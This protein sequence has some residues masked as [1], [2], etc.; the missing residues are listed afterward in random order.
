MLGKWSVCLTA[1][2]LC[3]GILL[4]ASPPLSLA[5][6]VEEMDRDAIQTLLGQRT[7]VNAKQ[8]D[9]M[10]AL[11]WAAYRDNLETARLLVNAGADVQA[12]N[13]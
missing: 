1:V 3:A 10:T 8:P 12:R 7:D 9:G 5:D 13:R 2:L 4:A 6:A 11:H